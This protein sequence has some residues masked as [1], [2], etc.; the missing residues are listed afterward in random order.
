MWG[1]TMSVLPLA[2]LRQALVRQDLD[3]FIVP[4]ADEHLSEYVPAG[5]ERLAWLT[6]FTGSA[7]I[8]VVLAVTAA[9]FTDGRYVLQLAEQTDAGAWQ[10]LHVTEEPP[11]AWLVRHAPKDGRI[12]YDPLLISQE[13]L[14][15]YTDAGL[16]MVAVERN[17]IDEVW[18]DRPAPP[19]APAE[20]HPLAYAGRSSEE[21]RAD[22]AKLLRDAGQ[23]TAVLTD[24][25]SIAWLLNIRGGDVPFTPFALGFA[26]VHADGATDLFMEPGKLSGATRTWL[27]NAVSV[28]G[29]DALGP[30]LAKL[31]GKTVRV[32]ASGSPVWFAQQLLKAGAIV[33]AASDPCLLPKACKNPTEQQGARQAHL[34]DAVAVCRFLH[35]LSV[36]APAGNQTEISAGEALLGFR[37]QVDGFRGESFPAISGAGEHG[38]IIHYRVTDE[39]NRPIKPN[40]V[41]LIDSGAQYPDGTT[42]I[43]RTVWTGPGDP[44]DAVRDRVT[45]VM[46]GHIAIA[47]AVFPRGVGGAHLDAF[48][49]RALWQAGLDY[50]HGTGHGVGSYLSVHEGPVSISRLAR[51]L[52]IEAGMI[53][54]N[55]PG[56]YLPDHYGIRLENLLLTQPAELPAATKPFLR[57][58]TLT[59]APFDRRLLKPTLMT[60]QEREWLDA[61]HARVLETIG[62]ALGQTE[63]AWLAVACAPLR[64]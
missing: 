27:G 25:A 49:R 29:R 22:V 61:Y 52:P 60:A 62:P 33:A 40:E 30:A 17:P 44:P 51:P 48:A 18:T 57:F 16:R 64:D 11:P 50:D 9:V 10:R 31:T 3:G 12:G 58:E 35:W 38:A 34:R 63:A 13:G 14:A 28:A 55:E 1:S 8:A 32:D 54:S 24:P 15:R 59:L 39:S 47:T 19:S 26:L 56:F 45:R 2:A 20:P 43:T 46:Q 41:Y 42:D 36:A 7:G 5:A 37:R 23:D 21:K 6:G 4:R 53:L